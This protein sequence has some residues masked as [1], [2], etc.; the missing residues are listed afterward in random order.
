MYFKGRYFLVQNIL[1]LITL[2]FLLFDFIC[3]LFFLGLCLIFQEHCFQFE[4]ILLFLQ[5]VYFF[6]KLLNLLF[7]ILLSLIHLSMLKS[8]ILLQ[9]FIL[10]DS[11]FHQILVLS[12][13]MLL[14]R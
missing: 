11:P 5:I 1:L 9:S 13:F 12:I 14:L 10:R 2:F 3:K 8:N 6:A 4:F 7:V